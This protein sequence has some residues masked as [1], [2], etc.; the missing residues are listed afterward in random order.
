MIEL[1]ELALDALGG[2]AVRATED[3]DADEIFDSGVDVREASASWV[4]E[5][6]DHSY[7]AHAIDG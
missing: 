6:I 5:L 3:V 1:L 2:A 4:R 7:G